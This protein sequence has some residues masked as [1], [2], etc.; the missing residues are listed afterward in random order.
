MIIDK[1]INARRYS[2]LHPGLEAALCFLRETD[3]GALPAGPQELD[4]TRLTINVIQAPCRPQEEV[5][6]EAHRKYIDVQYVV[7]GE[8]RFSWRP[9]SECVS[10]EAAFDEEKDFVLFADEPHAWFPLTADMFVVFF[11]EDAHGPM[12]GAGEMHKVVVKVAV[13]W[14]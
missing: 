5:K 2:A 1:L 4:G 12:C 7:A 14:D 9:T 10:P 6:L 13:D 3:L 8:E 11:P